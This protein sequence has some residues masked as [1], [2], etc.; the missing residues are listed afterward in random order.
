MLGT[1]KEYQRNT[2]RCIVKFKSNDTSERYV[3]DALYYLYNAMKGYEQSG[4]CCTACDC[5]G[6]RIPKSDILKIEFISN[7]YNQEII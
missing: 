1:L 7:P 4:R 2:T 3:G 6:K 5:K